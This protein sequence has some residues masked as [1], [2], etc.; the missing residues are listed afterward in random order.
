ME[1]LREKCVR[2]SPERT[3]IKRSSDG[4]K[5]VIHGTPTNDRN[6]FAINL[7]C[8]SWRKID[9][10]LHFSVRFLTNSTYKT[11]RNAIGIDEKFNEKWSGG[12]VF[13]HG[14][15]FPFQK[16]EPFIAV[17]WMKP[18]NLEIAVNEIHKYYKDNLKPCYTHLAYYKDI[19][20]SKIYMS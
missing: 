6:L 8:L 16:N 3:K 10:A 14:T 4:D 9:Y 13:R 15:K 19:S 7:E 12:H 18:P 20:V 17:M 5:L 2:E 1:S 11:G